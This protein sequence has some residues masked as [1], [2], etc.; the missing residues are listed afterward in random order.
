MC[1]LRACGRSFFSCSVDTASL[2]Y[3]ALVRFRATFHMQQPQAFL[4]GLQTHEASNTHT[5][6]TATSPTLLANASSLA[7]HKAVAM[8]EV[9]HLCCPSSRIASIN[10]KHIHATRSFSPSQPL[11][12][13]LLLPLAFVETASWIVV[14]LFQPGP[15][16]ILAGKY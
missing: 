12:S 8:S 14:P 5:R 16:P 7:I 11:H 4:A 3:A 13:L 6:V 10:H 9:H 2:V 15:T 1:F